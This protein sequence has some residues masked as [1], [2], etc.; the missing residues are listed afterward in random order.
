MAYRDQGIR[1][2]DLQHFVE[3][4]G[5]DWEAFEAS[6]IRRFLAKQDLPGRWD[7][8]HNSSKQ[9]R[10]MIYG[11]THWLTALAFHLEFVGAR[12]AD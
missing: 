2:T 3:I 1:I 5:Q 12:A 9:R 10:G 4:E 11:F 8:I 6:G 7:A